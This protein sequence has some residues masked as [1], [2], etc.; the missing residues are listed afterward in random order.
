MPFDMD[1]S[2]KKLQY[3]DEEYFRGKSNIRAGI[4]WVILV[5]LVSA[6]YYEKT[7]KG[8]YTWSWY[9]IL[10]IIGWLGYFAGGLILKIKGKAIKS[11]K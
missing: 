10:L 8:E 11:Y 3:Y 5:I 7:R 6:F 9:A 1:K 4:T 2:W